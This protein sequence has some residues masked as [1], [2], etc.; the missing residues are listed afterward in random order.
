RNYLLRL[1]WSHGDDEIITTEQAI[2]WFDLDHIGKSAARF[3][4]AKLEFVNAH[5]IKVAENQRLVDLVVP[6]LDKKGIA[7]DDTARARL[8]AGMD[9]LKSRAKTL[10][11]IADEGAFYARK[12][13]YAFDDKAK[14][15]LDPVV[16]AALKN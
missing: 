3:D 10:I 13:P 9:E 4:F 6:F 14:A 16:L 2:E 7:V 11:H 5:Y 15:N 12:I 8:M 1:G